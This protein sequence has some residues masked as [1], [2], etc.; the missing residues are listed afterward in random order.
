MSLMKAA[1]EIMADVKLGVNGYFPIL[2]LIFLLWS[3]KKAD[4]HDSLIVSCPEV[5]RD[6]RSALK[7][8]RSMV[9]GALWWWLVPEVL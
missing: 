9:I 6:P 5:C 8:H 2:L 7:R 4:M 3:S 1:V